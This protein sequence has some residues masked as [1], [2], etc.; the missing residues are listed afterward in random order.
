MYVIITIIILEVRGQFDGCLLSVF[1][2]KEV[3][4]MDTQEVLTLVLVIFAILTYLDDHQN[5]K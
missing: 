2:R 4:I 1:F 5:R 3:C